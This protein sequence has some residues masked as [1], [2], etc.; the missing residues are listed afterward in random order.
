MNS[1]SYC[2]GVNCLFAWNRNKFMLDE[3]RGLFIEG[4]EII[5]RCRIMGLTNL[6]VYITGLAGDCRFVLQ[7][8]FL[9]CL[10]PRPPPRP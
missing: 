4:W 7:Y 1:T 10:P 5:Y 8:L 6:L 2:E 9:P 3:T